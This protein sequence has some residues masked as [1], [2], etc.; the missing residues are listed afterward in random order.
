MSQEPAAA[1]FG[2]PIPA[3]SPRAAWD[4]AM[5]PDLEAAR[6]IEVG[7]PMRDGIELAADVHLPAADRLP[8]PAIVIGTPYDKSSPVD[9]RSVY[10]DHGYVV[11]SYDVRGRGKSEGIWHP[12]AGD[13]PDGHDVVEWVARQDWCTGSVGAEGLSYSGWVVWATIKEKPPHLTA[14]VAASPAGRWQQELPYTY[15][16]Y[17]LYF[18]FWFAFVRRRIIESE[19]D[20][21]PLLE[22][23]PVDRIGEELAVAGPGWREF[24]EHDSLDELWRSRRWDGEYDFDVPVLTVTG[25]H[26]REDIWG[27][28]HHYENMIATAP[29]ADRQWLLVGPWSHVSTRL[30]SDEYT[31]VRAPGAGIDMTALHVRYFDHFLKGEDNGVDAEPRVQMYDP[32]LGEWKVREAWEGGTGKREIFLAPG[33]ALAA[34]P[35]ADGSDPYVYDPMKPNGVPFDVN[36]LPWEPPLDLAELEAQDGVIGWSSEPL[37]EPLTV[38][39][40][41]E[42]ELWAESDREDTEFHVKLADVDPDGR[43]LFVAWGCLRASHAE[44]EAHPAAIVPGEVRRYSI[45]LTPSFHTF[46]P[47]HRLRLLLAGSEYP[48]FARNLNRFEPIA[49]QSEPLVATNAVHRG[50]AHPSCRRLPVEGV[51]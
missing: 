13:G 50:T 38:H 9:D 20:L 49:V 7:I 31:G 36:A 4:A 5:H 39:G 14:A 6:T 1:P 29:A 40:W 23:L 10:R 3:E 8:A 2:V 43:A 34:E 32:G 30:P 19:R 45:E 28:F 15:G 11:V 16:C 27:A 26:D 17:W 35:G 22:L 21:R 37:A 12:F 47:G 48:W 24:M 25:W 18:A 44:D 42:V 41:G 51:V 46:R 33:G